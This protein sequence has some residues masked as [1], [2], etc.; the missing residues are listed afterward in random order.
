MSA[1]NKLGAAPAP[2]PGAGARKGGNPS[3]GGLPKAWARTRWYGSSRSSHSKPTT[4]WMQLAA[5]TTCTG[6]T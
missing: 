4:T 1:P 6:R 3:Q 5:G 2:P